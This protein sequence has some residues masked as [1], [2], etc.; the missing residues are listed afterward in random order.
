[1]T[2]WMLAAFEGLVAV[3]TIAVWALAVY[4]GWG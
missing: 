3:G 4:L 1:M 2:P